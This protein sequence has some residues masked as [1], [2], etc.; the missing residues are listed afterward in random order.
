VQFD[1]HNLSVWLYD[2]ESS[3]A[4]DKVVSGWL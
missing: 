2:S 4:N 1:F 3:A